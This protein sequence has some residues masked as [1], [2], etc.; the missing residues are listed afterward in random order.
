MGVVVM[1]SSF[2]CEFVSERTGAVEWM[3]AFK[4]VK[5]FVC[6]KGMLLSVKTKY[7]ARPQER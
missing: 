6:V 2:A 7:E 1:D 3:R 4:G 5:S